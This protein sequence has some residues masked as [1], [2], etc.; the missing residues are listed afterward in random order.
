MLL[1]IAY[2]VQNPAEAAKLYTRYHRTI[3]Q[4]RNGEPVTGAPPE[5]STARILHDPFLSGL[6]TRIV[7]Q[8][9]D[10]RRERLEMAR[11]EQ[12]ERRR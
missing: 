9:E 6:L 7:K 11:K 2:A 10:K 3:D 5:S 8:R 12:H 4:L 1:T